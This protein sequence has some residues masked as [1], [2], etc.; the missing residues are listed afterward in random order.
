[1][2]S[3]RTEWPLTPNR[4]HQAVEKRRAAGLPIIDLTVSNPSQVGLRWPD[5]D[6]LRAALSR[7]EVLTYAPEPFGAIEARAALAGWF[8]DHGLSITPERL[9]LTASTSEAY[10]FLFKLVCNPGDAVL[11]PAPS[12]PLFEYL[13][14]L[15]EV[16]V[17]PYQLR[18][19]GEWHVDQSSLDEALSHPDATPRAI[20]AI[21]PNNPTG[22]YLKPSEL[23]LLIDRCAH[24][25]LALISDEVFYEHSLSE[26]AAPAPR[27]ATRDECL[28]FS[29]GGLS[30]LA[31]LPQLKLAWIAASGP[32]AMLSSALARLEII[33]DTFL[34]VSAPAQLA[35]PYVLGG[36]DAFVARSKLRLHRN[37]LALD[38]ALTAAP[39][40][41]RLRCEGGWNAMVRLPA[42]RSSE[43]WAIQLLEQQGVL[44]QPGY[45]YDLGAALSA[46]ASVVLSLLCEEEPFVLGASGLAGASGLGGALAGA[47]GLGA[48][49]RG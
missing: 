43:D 28:V 6:G 2:F 4:L 21:H 44:V 32:A 16:A 26:R 36:V 33:A 13:A 27:A 35:L 19:D 18:Y 15:D 47:S 3:A 40:A 17:V 41:T 48:T 10:A 38:R 12:Y 7:A 34:S 31:G 11:I 20:V 5:P 37:L 23:D 25:G 42:T 45:F 14:N 46:D 49:A 8:A 9:C 22:Q 30:K 24:R 29:L 39:A 1:M